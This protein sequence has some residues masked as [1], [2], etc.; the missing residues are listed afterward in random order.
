MSYFPYYLNVRQKKKQKLV[1]FLDLFR[2]LEF[3]QH[4]NK[5]QN[6]FMGMVRVP[7]WHGYHLYLDKPE[8]KKMFCLFFLILLS[9]LL[10][11]VLFSISLCFYCPRSS[12]WQWCN[13]NLP[14]G[15]FFCIITWCP[16]SELCFSN[17]YKTNIKNN[18]LNYYSLC[19]FCGEGQIYSNLFANTEKLGFV[20]FN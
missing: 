10:S 5:F 9:L 13:S 17:S 4:A 8:S 18:S 3:I 2:L 14:A 20:F 6:M 16:S 1:T 7:L 12:C 11:V 19:L 15:D